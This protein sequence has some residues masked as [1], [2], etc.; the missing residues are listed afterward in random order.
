VRILLA[1]DDE[2]MARIAILSLAKKGG[3]EV[4]HARNGEEAVAMARSE[5]PDM[6]LMDML[7]PRVDGLEA[8]RRIKADGATAGIPII[9]LTAGS[10]KTFDEA[11]KEA[12]GAGIIRKPFQ[13]A[14]LSARVE[15]ILAGS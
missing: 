4:L 5:K 3:H 11:M 8:C 7:M 2:A 15:E 14:E 12:G 1:E 9:F 6:V 13:P 10:T